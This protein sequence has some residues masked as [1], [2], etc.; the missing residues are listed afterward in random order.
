MDR[1]VLE[2][3][4]DGGPDWALMKSSTDRLV[5]LCGQYAGSKKTQPRG[6][7]WECSWPTCPA[8]C[9]EYAGCCRCC[10]SADLL[11]PLSTELWLVKQRRAQSGSCC[12]HM[13]PLAVT[14]CFLSPVSGS[15]IPSA[16][17][18]TNA[19]WHCCASRTRIWPCPKQA[20]SKQ[21]ND[22]WIRRRLGGMLLSPLNRREHRP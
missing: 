6:S 20:V 16:F 18:T 3:V 7:V 22:R 19:E 4:P 13:S 8:T 1:W 9:I 14:C 21:R 2:R 17:E 11:F 12:L 15:P 10:P 5:A